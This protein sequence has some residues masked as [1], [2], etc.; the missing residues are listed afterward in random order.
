MYL[1]CV[2]E[3]CDAA[4]SRDFMD[5]EGGYTE[6][7]L[8]GLLSGYDDDADDELKVIYVHESRSIH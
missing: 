7:S 6:L 8:T 4:C 1:F 3:E 5:H 2:I